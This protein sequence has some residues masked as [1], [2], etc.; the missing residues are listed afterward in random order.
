MD[1]GGFIYCGTVTVAQRELRIGFR[2]QC[3]G[4]DQACYCEHNISD[5]T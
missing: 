2:K 3:P 1:P 5:G 4:R